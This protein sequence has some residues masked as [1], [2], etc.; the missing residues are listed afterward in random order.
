MCVKLPPGGLNPDSYPP[1][2]ISTYTCE[3]T[4]APKVRGGS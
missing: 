3:V 4:T 1:H 2:P